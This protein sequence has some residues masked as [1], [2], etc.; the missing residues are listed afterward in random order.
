MIVKETDVISLKKILDEGSDDVVVIDVRRDDERH[1]CFIKGTVHIPLDNLPNR[2]SE[3][4]SHK[5]IYFHCKA[6]TRS[7][8]ACEAMMKGGFKNVYNVTGGILAWKDAGFETQSS[9]VGNL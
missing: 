2:F 8:S 4:S 1:E 3:V 9:S 7:A 5:I 6:G